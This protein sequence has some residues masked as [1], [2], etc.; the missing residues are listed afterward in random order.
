M[1]TEPVFF[2]EMHVPQE[3]G[4]FMQSQI[5]ATCDFCANYA[6]GV[7]FPDENSDVGQPEA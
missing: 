6:V 4:R 7:F 2:C 3:K 1:I 5:P